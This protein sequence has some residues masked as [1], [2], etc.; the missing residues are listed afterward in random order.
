MWLVLVEYLAR[1]VYTTLTVLA[2]NV[3]LEYAPTTVALLALLAT[4]VLKM[5]TVIAG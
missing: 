3:R 2:V 4:H 1:T 5:R